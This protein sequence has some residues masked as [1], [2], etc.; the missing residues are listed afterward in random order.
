M[1]AARSTA[2]P[3][4]EKA[5][6]FPSTSRMLHLGQMADAMSRSRAISWPQP[7]LPAGSGLAWPFWLTLL[8]Q[9]TAGAVDG[10]VTQAGRAG[11]PNAARYVLRSLKAAGLS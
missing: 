9:A 11:I 4:S 5:A 10:G 1:A 8:K 2:A 7:T 6:E 3:R